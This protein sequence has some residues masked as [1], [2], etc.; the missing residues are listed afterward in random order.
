MTKIKLL[1]LVASVIFL[2]AFTISTATTWNIAEDHSIQ[3]NSSKASGVFTEFV[4]DIQFDE[5]NLA[6]S[7][8]DVSIDVASIDT[9]NGMKNRH[10]KGKKW[11]DAKQFPSINYSSE[12]ITQ[13][14][15][16]F[17][18]SGTLEIRGIKK[19]LTMP[20]SFTDNTFTSN[21]TVNRTD[22]NIGSTKGMAKSVPQEIELSISVP[23]TN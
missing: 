10:A 4:G 8:F 5:N 22:F 2:S 21:F 3:F 17:E 6:A 1:G 16:G 15:T 12:S 13:T 9:G 11:F 18:V 23:V 19:P 7:K 14:A 20:F